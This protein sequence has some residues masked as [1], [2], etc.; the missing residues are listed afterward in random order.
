MTTKND[1]WQAFTM[2][3]PRASSRWA[4]TDRGW[5]FR[6]G[7]CRGNY[8]DYTPFRTPEQIA[9]QGGGIHAVRYPG[10]PDGPS[11]YRHCATIE[12]AQHWIEGQP[13]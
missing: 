11:E 6:S 12:D 13:S 10:G 4:S 2:N 7:L 8:L 3:T 5:L 1:G 9:E